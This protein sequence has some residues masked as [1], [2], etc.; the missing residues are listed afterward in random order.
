MIGVQVAIMPELATKSDS[1]SSM[2]DCFNKIEDFSRD[3]CIAVGVVMVS[4]GV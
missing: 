1:V 4:G 2:T 3:C